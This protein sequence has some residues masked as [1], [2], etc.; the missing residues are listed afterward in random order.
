MTQAK[1]LR[2]FDSLSDPNLI[3]FSQGVVSS[4]TDNPH[5]PEPFPIPTPSRADT[6]GAVKGFSG[7]YQ[8]ALCHDIYKIA[9]RNQARQVLVD[10][11]KRLAHY[12]EMVCNGD[13]AVLA[14]SGFK[15]RQDPVRSGMSSTHLAAPT[16]L[17]LATGTNR[18]EVDLHAAKLVGAQ[19]H[20]VQIC[21]GDPTVE[22]NWAHKDT[23]TS[24]QQATIAGLPAGPVWVRVRGG[25]SA[26]Y[27]DWSGAVCVLV[28]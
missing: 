9:V 22:A 26:G 23:F 8:D 7:A 20:E 12:L 16:E 3:I 5:F 17:H 18:G 25:N 21:T 28:N 11:L 13:P 2:D 6:A 19:F 27:G 1:I 10:V 15:L 14:T 4:L 24:L